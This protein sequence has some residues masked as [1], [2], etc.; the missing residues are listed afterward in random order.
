MA[1]GA[2]TGGGEP[3]F[4]ALVTNDSGTQGNGPRPKAFG[5]DT[6]VQASPRRKADR[7]GAASSNRPSI[8]PCYTLFGKRK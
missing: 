7:R 3:T 4:A 2:D 8:A 6:L 1:P 5:G